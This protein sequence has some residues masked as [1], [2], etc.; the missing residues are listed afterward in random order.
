M[1]KA[2]KG[3]PFIADSSREKL[4]L[5]LTLPNGCMERLLKRYNTTQNATAIRE[6]INE[7]LGIKEKDKF[8][9]NSSRQKRKELARELNT[10]VAKINSCIKKHNCKLNDV[11]N[12]ASE[13]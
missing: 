4:S 9:S 5:T 8:D 6:G 2:K 13:L 12:Y 10:T 1:A 11:A 3:R 7:L